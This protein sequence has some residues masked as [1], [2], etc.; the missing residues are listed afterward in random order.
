M[1]AKHVR[2]TA[3]VLCAIIT[4]T[5]L[6]ACSNT[7][8][9]PASDFDYREISGGVEITGYI[10]DSTEVSIPNVIA[11]AYV[12][13]I[14]SQAFQNRSAITRII[15]P[16]SV[17]QIN[18]SAFRDCTG[19]TSITVPDSVSSIE[20]SGISID[21]ELA[22]AEARAEAEAKA[23]AEAQTKAKARAEAEARGEVLPVEMPSGGV[24]VPRY[25]SAFGGCSNLTKAKYKGKTYSVISWENNTDLPKEFYDAVNGE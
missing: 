9:N 8:V 25:D 21:D 22:K 17:K 24:V 23:K 12:I 10:G 19:L 20:G 7:P 1:K 14:G 4:A 3:F 2:I 18:Y 16:D 11:G 15:I 13:S 6:M 5:A